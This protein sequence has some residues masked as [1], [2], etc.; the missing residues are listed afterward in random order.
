[1]SKPIKRSAWWRMCLP[2]LD[3]QLRLPFLS[4]RTALLMQSDYSMTYEYVALEIILYKWNFRFR[5][6]NTYERYCDRD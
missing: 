3:F 2:I 1:M 6:Y 4:V 5:L